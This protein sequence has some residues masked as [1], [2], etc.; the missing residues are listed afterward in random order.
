MII[1][2]FLFKIC[3]LKQNSAECYVK[4]RQLKASLLKN[5]SGQ[6]ILHI[7]A[8]ENN[9]ELINQV[10]KREFNENIDCKYKRINLIN[11]LIL[12]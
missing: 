9:T 1:Y 4:L 10:L 5:I 8:L 7:A 3:K 6:N 12:S 11:E 2:T